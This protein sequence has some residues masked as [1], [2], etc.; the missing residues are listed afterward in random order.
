MSDSAESSK[1]PIEHDSTTES[2]GDYSDVDFDPL[3]IWKGDNGSQKF[4][5]KAMR[6]AQGKWIVWNS[7]KS[8]LFPLLALL[9]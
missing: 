6:S 2:E 7:F 9:R 8:R 3:R 4:V 1:P 5:K